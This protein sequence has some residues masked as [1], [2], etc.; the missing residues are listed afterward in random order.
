MIRS[1]IA[2]EI[3]R[4]I[5]N[6]ITGMIGEWDRE[7]YPVRWVKEDN[8]HLTLKFLGEIKEEV[9]FDV[10]SKLK[11][12]SL[13]FSPFE[14][15]LKGLGAFPTPKSP[16]V[17]WIGI[18]K[19]REGVKSLQEVVENELAL[20]GLK[21]ETREFSPHL[22]IGRAKAKFDPKSILATQYE[23]PVFLVRALALFKSTL[24]PQGPIYEKLEEFPLS[25]GQ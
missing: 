16:R 11:S 18:A 5:R 4:E 1:F 10:S 2:I 9:V 23:S 20:V 12:I 8:L 3:P 24:T 21:P 17:L 14:F 7:G 15:S 25:A 22:T 6:K 13:R 19:G